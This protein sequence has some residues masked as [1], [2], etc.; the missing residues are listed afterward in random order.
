MGTN[1]FLKNRNF[2]VIMKKTTITIGIPAYNE[3]A[4]IQSLVFS[5]LSQKNVTYDIDKL[6]VVAD[7]CTDS[8]VRK[9]RAIKDKRIVL[10]ENK[11]RR[12]KAYAL[13][14][15]AKET[16]SD[17]LVHLDA[18]ILIKDPMLL[19]KLIDPVLN[20]DADLTS[21][22]VKEYW[23]H[24]KLEQVLKISMNLKKEIFEDYK[25]GDNIYTCHGRARALTKRLYKKMKFDE[26][27]VAED[28]FSYLFAI[29]NGY[30]YRFARNANVYYRLPQTLQD[31]KKQS[32]R[33]F[34]S[35][36]QLKRVF[37]STFLKSEIRLPR[38][39]VIKHSIKYLVRYPLTFLIY[40][41]ILIKMKIN[42][43]V[44]RMTTS[45]WSVSKSS[46]AFN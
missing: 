38:S 4:N 22:R 44:E 19:C 36:K 37:G 39:I 23:A 42:A 41:G 33:F 3:E 26:S 10:F 45:T 1:V 2:Y 31:H 34:N 29:A 28:A 14:L 17:I 32:V 46:K 7:N 35:Y 15:I 24:S 16:T 25:N 30:T 21:A 43:R 12:G 9:V 6:V 11:K 27:I 5:V 40:F 18:D 13:N 8:T 20:K